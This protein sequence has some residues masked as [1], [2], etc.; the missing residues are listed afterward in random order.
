MSGIFENK[1]DLCLMTMMIAADDGEWADPKVDFDH[2][3]LFLS[4][5]LLSSNLCRVKTCVRGLWSFFPQFISICHAS[6]PPPPLSHAPSS[7]QPR[8]YTMH[9]LRYYPILIH[10]STFS[11]FL[12][13]RTSILICIHLVL[14]V[15]VH[16]ENLPSCPLPCPPLPSPLPSSLTQH[17]LR[18]A[19]MHLF[20]PA[21]E[22]S[23]VL[24]KLSKKLLFHR[25]FLVRCW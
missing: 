2:I 6:S 20:L 5:F 4:F 21:D 24:L 1:H 25:S 3:W 7:L 10:V 14:P 22:Q 17:F 15:P 12:V 13:F 23:P 19:F 16:H 11:N 9:H 18:P 8:C